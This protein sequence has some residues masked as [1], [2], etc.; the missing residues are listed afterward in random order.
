MS[1]TLGDNL[2]LVMKSNNFMYD[3]SREVWIRGKYGAYF[4]G[5]KNLVIKY[6]TKCVK[7]ENQE[8]Q[9][10]VT[11]FDGRYNGT[12]GLDNII[13]SICYER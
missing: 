11:V 3:E 1:T 10:R 5:V 4:S 12:A 13:Q 2:V 6:L 7:N 9:V 8:V